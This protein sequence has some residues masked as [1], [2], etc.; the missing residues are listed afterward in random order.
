MYMSEK[1][2]LLD[3]VNRGCQR[4]LAANGGPLQQE[5]NRPIGVR[6]P[7]T[8]PELVAQIVSMARAGTYTAKQIG[9]KL[10][11]SPNIVRHIAYYRGIHLP[12][13]RTIQLF[14]NV[15]NEPRGK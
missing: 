10:D 9:S 15:A 5:H 14:A 2:G 12:D 6:K 1:E 3:V 13:E 11:V 8:S 4:L 7:R